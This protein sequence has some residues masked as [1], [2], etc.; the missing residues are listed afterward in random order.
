MRGQEAG[1]NAQRG[2][3]SASR[4]RRL[5]GGF[6]NMVRR[7]GLIFV[8]L[9]RRGDAVKLAT[10]AAAKKGSSQKQDNGITKA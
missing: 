3:R 1:L 9:P 2:G 7:A 5:T 6:R 8:V 4:S 10:K